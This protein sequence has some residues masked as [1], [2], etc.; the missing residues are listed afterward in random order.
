M[1][2][3]GRIHA[4][5][6]SFSSA[7]IPTYAHTCT[8]T[9]IHAYIHAYIH[10]RHTQKYVNTHICI[11]T[12]YDLYTSMYTSNTYTYIQTHEQEFG[13]WKDL[14]WV[15]LGARV[16]GNSVVFADHSGMTRY[17]IC[18]ICMCRYIQV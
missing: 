17:A 4:G 10:F 15:S 6:L 9:Y 5:L 11:Q 16:L 18:A 1:H 12:I 7:H 3:L 13:K 2:M 14:V 8:H